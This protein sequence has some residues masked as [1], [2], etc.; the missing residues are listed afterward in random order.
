MRRNRRLYIM[1]LVALLAVC[2][3]AVPAVADA[4]GFSG[5]SDY[6]G[7]GS[8]WGGSDWGSSDWESSDYSYSSGGGSGGSP[9]IV[10]IVVVFLIMAFVAA[11][12][13]KGRTG[14]VVGGAA[15]SFVPLTPIE[16]LR[17]KDPYF[18]ENAMR[19]K[20]ANLYV[21]MQ[22]AWEDKKFEPM[23]AHMTDALYNQFDRQLEELRRAGQTNFIDRIAVLSVELTGWR[24]DYRNDAIVA[25]VNTRIIDYTVDDKTGKVVSGS[26]TAEKFM[27]YEW[28]LIRSKDMKTPAPSGEGREQTNTIHCPSCGAPVEIN[29][30]AKCP[31]C[32]S[33]IS[34]R[35]YDWVVS[36]I[37]GLAQRT[38]N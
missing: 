21:Q 29:Q 38:G 9:G 2:I 15:Q 19:E 20:I 6:G 27:T 25:I 36:A 11:R 23:R 3:L 12:F 10:V 1:L 14:T 4:G 7:G 37:K 17:Q 31:Y 28:T 16:A 32:D 24:E 35:D 8:D 22:H 30:S 5:G 33:V 18:S 26:K 13:K 34:A